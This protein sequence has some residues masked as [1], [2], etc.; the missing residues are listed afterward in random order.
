MHHGLSI[1]RSALLVILQSVFDMFR[2]PCGVPL[3]FP[4]LAFSSIVICCIFVKCS[5]VFAR[6]NG[7]CTCL[8]QSLIP[9]P[10]VGVVRFS[11]KPLLTPPPRPLLSAQL[12]FQLSSHLSIG[13]DGIPQYR[14]AALLY[15]R[16]QDPPVSLRCPPRD[17]DRLLATTG[18]PSIAQMPESNG[19]KQSRD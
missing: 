19:E 6:P 3:V 13:D 18:S 4:N 8:T 16:R 2:N 1:I 7:K 14:S 5:L 9:H 15:R 12:T 10:Q 17:R 11:S